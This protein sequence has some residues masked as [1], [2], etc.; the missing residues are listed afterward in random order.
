MRTFSSLLVWFYMYCAIFVSAEEAG[1]CDASQGTCNGPEVPAV[2]IAKGSNREGK[3]PEVSFSDC[4]DRHDKC[5]GF[6]RQGECDNNPGWMI[7]NCPKSC[8]A[9]HLRDPKIRCD[10]NFLNISDSPIYAPGDM[11]AM[12]ASIKDLYDARYGVDV[13]STSPWMVTFD[14]FLTDNEVSA[15]ISTVEGK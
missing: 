14:H 11:H 9:C 1:T 15:L 5:P 3:P 6:Q 13:I 7:V 10:R 8:N 4:S 2:K 12:F